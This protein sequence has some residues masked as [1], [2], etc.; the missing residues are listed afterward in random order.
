MRGFSLLEMVAVLAIAMVASSIFF[1]NLM[2]ALKQV[3]VTNAFNTALSTMRRAH[4]AAVAKRGVLIVTF[5]APRTMTVAQETA[6]S[7]A[8]FPTTTT[9][10][11]DDMSFTAIS[12]LPNPGPDQFG[13]GATAIDFAQGISGGV[14]NKIYFHP[15]GS[16]KDINKNINSGVVY[17]ARAGELWTTRAI[18]VWGATGRIRGFRLE[19]KPSSSGNYWR[20]Q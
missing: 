8:W 6:T 10:L 14:Q 5:T 1:I 15:D 7:P 13:T 4:D 11:P 17:I 19:Q 16:A 18:T 9:T 2:P 12:G 20:L 3:R